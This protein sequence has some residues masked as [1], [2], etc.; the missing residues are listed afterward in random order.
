P[1]RRPASTRTSRP[2]TRR[3]RCRV[4]HGRT[5]CRRRRWP[6]WSRSTPTA[7]RWASSASPGWTCWR[8]TPPSPPCETE[9]MT[10]PEGVQRRG[11]LLVYL[12]A[13]PGVGKTFAMLDEAH[14][15]RARGT[16][17]VVGLVETHGRPNTLA[18]LEG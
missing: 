12:G 7:G 2:P 18:K 8:S 4:W 13:A 11:R 3:S 6:G 16:D 9:A 10:G 14:R 5:A 1:H 15:R 17:V